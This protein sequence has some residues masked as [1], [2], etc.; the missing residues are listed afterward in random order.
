MPVFPL[1]LKHRFSFSAM[2]VHRR[3]RLIALTKA[4]RA[5]LAESEPLWQ[6][7]QD[8]FEAAFGAAKSATLRKALEHI[9]SEEFVAAFAHRD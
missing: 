9:V 6:R 3:N 2:A 7:A 5:K 1:G 4:G 8:G